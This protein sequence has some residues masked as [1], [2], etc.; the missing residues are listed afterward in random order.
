[1]SKCEPTDRFREI[2]FE[3]DAKQFEAWTRDRL[4]LGDTVQVDG[5]DGH[6]FV[7][8]LTTNTLCEIEMLAK[9]KDRPK[10]YPIVEVR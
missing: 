8:A 4:K 1:M 7:R 10:L 5:Y 3:Q 2:V 6:W 9:A